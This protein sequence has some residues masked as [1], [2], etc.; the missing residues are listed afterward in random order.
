ME[1][2]ITLRD[3]KDFVVMIQKWDSRKLQTSTLLAVVT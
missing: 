3:Q 2:I 1:M